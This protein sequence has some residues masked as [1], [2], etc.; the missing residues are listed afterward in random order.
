MPNP[1]YTGWNYFVLF[2]KTYWFQSRDMEN[3]LQGIADQIYFE[4]INA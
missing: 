2:S 3:E 1:K 4:A